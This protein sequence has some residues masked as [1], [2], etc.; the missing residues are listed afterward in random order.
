[1]VIQSNMSPK[2]IIS[3]WEETVAV[4]EKYGIAV[5][6]DHSLEELV[7]KEKLEELLSKL[8]LIIGSTDRTCIGGG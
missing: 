4:F 8:N 5:G 3:V 2:A 7:N 6:S 1:M